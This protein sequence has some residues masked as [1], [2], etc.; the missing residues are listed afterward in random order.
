MQF[1]TD[2]P[3]GSKF[4][5]ANRYT[6]TEI[7]E[8]AKSLGIKNISKK[9]MD[10]LCKE[11]L[12]IVKTKQ[13]PK[14]PKQ[15]APKQQQQL[16]RRFQELAKLVADFLQSDEARQEDWEIYDKLEPLTMKHL[17]DLQTGV[18][19]QIYVIG[20]QSYKTIEVIDNL[21]PLQQIRQDGKTRIGDYYGKNLQDYAHVADWER[22]FLVNQHN[23][24]VLEDFYNSN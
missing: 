15:Q 10:T 20:P 2:K 18:Y 11:I 6:K 12:D 3:C 17:K 13:A 16:R 14:Q 7:V 5:G 1:K 24:D 19:D 21:S 8:I 22:S 4:R 9:N 23:F